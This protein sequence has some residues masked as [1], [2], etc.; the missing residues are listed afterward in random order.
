MEVFVARQAIFDQN[1]RV[2]GYE[3]LFRA[4]ADR[5]EFDAVAGTQATAEV[6]S[7]CVFAVGLDNLRGG[8]TA[9]VNFDR[10]MLLQEWYKMLPPKTTVIELLETITPDAEVIAA[11]RSLSKQGYRIALDDFVFRAGYEPLLE[12]ANVVKVEIGSLPRTEQE[13]TVR[14]YHARKLKVVAEKVET[15]EEF[16]W[17]RKAGYDFF[18]GYFFARP[19]VMRGE[20]ILA[21]KAN[22]LRLLR[23]VQQPELDFNC[24]G[25]LISEDVAFSYKLIRYASSTLFARRGRIQSIR[26]ALTTMGEDNIR[27]WV[28]LVTLSKVAEDK[29]G[30]LVACS[31]VR[32]K[33]C[34]LMGNLVGA[35]LQEP[36]F[37]MGL[38][39]MLDALLDRPLD[40]ALAEVRLAP[41]IT[42]ALLGLAPE[43]D[44]LTGLYK[45]ARR[46]EAADWEEVDRLVGE[47]KAPANLALQA[48]GDAVQWANEALILNAT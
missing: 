42:A 36:A 6:I 26:Q 30:E 12:I 46:Y 8:K 21:A 44:A 25:E 41:G 34:E 47:L 24:L 31:L 17:A 5:N 3:L 28:S 35:G 23:E 37:L 2:Q 18:Q 38:F 13:N 40:E 43:G 39:S 27:R 1:R 45:L 48:Y 33:F 4:T 22:Y 16:E 9:F 15:Y 32:A 7:N 11:C 14:A 20:Q 10:R 29:P 19:K